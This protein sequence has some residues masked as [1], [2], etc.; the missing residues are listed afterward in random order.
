MKKYPNIYFAGQ[1]SGVEGYVESIMSGLVASISL[2]RRLDEM[3]KIEF[4]NKCIIGAICQYLV[5]P[6][7]NFQP[8][9]AN[10][11]ILEPLQEKVKDKQK[12]KEAY[13][14]R[15]IE[16]IKKIKENYNGI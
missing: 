4:N 7:E 9:N 1:I 5:A 16:E 14:L 15:A 2:A 10:F 11:G 6:N 8:M 3:P 12:R 13:S